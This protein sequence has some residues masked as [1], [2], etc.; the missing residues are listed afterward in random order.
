MADESPKASD[1]DAV[2]ECPAYDAR[3][4]PAVAQKFYALGATK[5][6]IAETFGISSD[7]ISDWEVDHQE[8]Y[9][10]CERG[11]S[12]AA[13]GLEVALYQL[14]IGP[15]QSS[16]R[17]KKVHG[18][19]VVAEEVRQLPPNIAA[20]QFWLTNRAPKYWN[21]ESK[22]D[23]NISDDRFLRM[24][25]TMKF[26]TYFDILREKEERMKRGESWEDV[27]AK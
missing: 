2:A 26:R 22:T 6:D 3:L 14:A 5:G 9:E 16:V 27:H 8:F 1:A 11:R 18:E 7:T 23:R 25:K 21:H 24:L 15:V 10:A 12:T 17:L 4:H 20:L 19:L 13:H